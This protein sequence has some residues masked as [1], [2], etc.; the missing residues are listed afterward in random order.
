MIDILYILCFI[1]IAAKQ[2]GYHDPIRKTDHKGLSTCPNKSNVF[3]ECSVWCETHWKGVLTPDARYVRNMH[4]LLAKYPLPNAW[5]EVF[6][7]GL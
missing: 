7:K 3:H 2:K 6:D 4:K 5:I 1:I